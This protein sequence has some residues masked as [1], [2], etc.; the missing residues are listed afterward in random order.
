MSTR[1]HIPVT[2]LALVLTLICLTG[3]NEA[4]SDGPMTPYKLAGQIL[5]RNHEQNTANPLV[6]VICDPSP[7]VRADGSGN[8]E[9]TETFQ[10]G[11]M[12]WVNF[13]VNSDGSWTKSG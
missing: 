8:Y 3:C 9:C 13:V 2:L 1:A 5:D 6:S 4:V 11:G 7:D 12:S 10:S